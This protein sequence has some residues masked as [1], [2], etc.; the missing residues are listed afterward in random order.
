MAAGV[1]S[2]GDS[3]FIHENR[4][5]S[6][7]EQ[8]MSEG[9]S[10]IYRHKSRARDFEAVSGDDQNIERISRHIEEHVGPVAG[11]F[12]EIVSDLVHIDLHVVN[13]SPERNYYTLITSGMS[14][15]PMSPPPGA[16]EH[17][18][19]ELMICLPPDWPLAYKD[20]EDES[21]YWPIRWLKILARLPH[22]YQTWLFTSHTVPNGDPAEPFAE[23]TEMCC[24]LLLDPVLFD[25]EFRVLE[26]DKKKTVHFLA[27][28]PL[29]VEEME[30]K[31]REGYDVL[32]R[33][34]DE[35]GVNEL[36]NVRRKNACRGKK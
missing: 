2:A 26:I 23:N 28:V 3:N 16:E 22:E 10:P 19:A 32:I 14:D 4:V 31:L 8:E 9:G 18:F 24:A 5:M 34:L 17:R 7:N 29:Y 11:V 35:A 1:R 30:C 21:N 12:H 25:D 13:P 6:E 15:R 33:R 36:L 27:L 20:F